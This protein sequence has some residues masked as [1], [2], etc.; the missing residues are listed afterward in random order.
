MKIIETDE[1]CHFTNNHHFGDET[2]LFDVNFNEFV[3]GHDERR[4][5]GNTRR[6]ICRQRTSTALSREVT[7]GSWCL[8]VFI[9]RKSSE[10]LSLTLTDE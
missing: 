6:G 4:K 8:P 2:E 10:Q 9:G 7:L 1:A 3:E 5:S